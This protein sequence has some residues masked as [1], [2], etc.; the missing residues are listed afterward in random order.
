MSVKS[1]SPPLFTT[2]LVVIGLPNASAS[3]LYT[4]TGTSNSALV[5]SGNV[6][7]TVPVLVPSFEVSIL[8]FVVSTTVDPSGKSFILSVKSILPFLGILSGSILGFSLYFSAWDLSIS[9]STGYSFVDPSAKVI[10]IVAF[11]FPDF[12]GSILLSPT[13]SAVASSGIF[14]IMSFGVTYLPY[15]NFS[16]LISGVKVS[17]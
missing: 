12:V 16:S 10:L 6:T 14:L 13:N 17:D 1:I 8:S 9:T 3:V 5:P 11:C 4:S 2:S 15:G 7:S